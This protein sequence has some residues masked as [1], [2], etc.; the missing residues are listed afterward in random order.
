MLVHKFRFLEGFED[1][2]DN[3]PK[4]FRPRINKRRHGEG[5]PYNRP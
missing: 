4:Y 5:R 2:Q 1:R 3:K